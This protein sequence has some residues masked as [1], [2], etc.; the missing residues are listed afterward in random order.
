MSVLVL[1]C[2][3]CNREIELKRN[4]TSVEFIKNCIITQGCRGTLYLFNTLKDFTRG[5]NSKSVSGLTDWNQRKVLFDFTQTTEIDTWSIKHNTR[6]FPSVFAFVNAPTENEPNRIEQK[7]PIDIKII[8]ENNIVLFFDRAYSGTAQLIT[9]MTFPQNQVFTSETKSIKRI[10]L[11][12]E[13]ELTIALKLQ[14]SKSSIIEFISMWHFSTG[15]SAKVNYNIDDVQS[16]LSPWRSFQ[17]IDV[18]GV[19]YEVRS[20]KIRNFTIPAGSHVSFKEFSP[21]ENPISK[22]KQAFILITKPPFEIFDIDKT[23][24][25]DLSDIINDELA[26]SYDGFEVSIEESKLK[27]IFPHAICL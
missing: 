19:I 17:N 3:T 2:T 14:N 27:N 11:S 20:F 24:V 5:K 16:S 4:K 23:R 7:E 10:Q 18:D 1:K 25:L 15:L 6:A 22:P 13:G 26:I 21:S 9:N 8:D 12:N